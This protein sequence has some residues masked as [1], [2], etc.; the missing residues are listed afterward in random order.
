MYLPAGSIHLF[1]VASPVSVAEADPASSQKRLRVSQLIKFNW[2]TGAAL[3]S[4]VT[5]ITTGSH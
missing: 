4:N 5:F 2:V 1:A 3:I